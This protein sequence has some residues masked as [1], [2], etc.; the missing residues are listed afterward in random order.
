MNRAAGKL[1]KLLELSAFF[2]LILLSACQNSAESRVLW[3]EADIRVCEL[4]VHNI[5]CSKPYE[6]RRVDDDAFKE[7]VILLCAELT[8]Y[9][10]LISSDVILGADNAF[11]TFVGDS[12]KYTISF[13]EA[14]EQLSISYI[15]RDIPL[16]A[17]AIEE[18]DEFGQP[19]VVAQWFCSMATTDF[20]M[21]YDAVQT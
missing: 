1:L 3:S 9:R 10:P 19:H 17:A 11:L 16:V 12:K 6:M 2:I 20:A 7:K 8:P 13:V 18:F 15:H 14:E 5:T 4:L 21:L